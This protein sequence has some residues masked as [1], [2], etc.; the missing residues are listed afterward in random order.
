MAKYFVKTVQAFINEG[1]ASDGKNTNLCHRYLS[2][3]YCYSYFYNNRGHFTEKLQESCSQ[4]WSYL[5][6]WGMLR[7]SS[8]LLQNSYACLIPLIKHFDETDTS[9]WDIDV[10]KYLV[11]NNIDKITKEY[12]K[13][14]NILEKIKVSPTVTLVTK[15]MLGV[16]AC[17]PAYDSYFTETFRGIYGNE[18]DYKKKCSFW[19]FDAMSL[20][21]IADFYEKHKVEV[22]KFYEETKVRELISGHETDLHYTK[23]K[24][25]D[26]YGFEYGICQIKK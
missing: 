14:E 24:I 21:C 5:A 26:M 13:I 19:T 3:D 18:D 9:L 11:G 10:D 15:I 25:I 6:S 7:G 22:D 4:L 16:Y 20:Q 2:F 1:K 12:G 8:K 17:V 23:A